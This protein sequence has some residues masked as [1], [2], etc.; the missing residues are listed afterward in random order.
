MAQ[1][2]HS[3]QIPRKTPLQ[4]GSLS[5]S[6]LNVPSTAHN[7]EVAAGFQSKAGVRQKSPGGA[8]IVDELDAGFRRA[9]AHRAVIRVV[10]MSRPDQLSVAQFEQD[11]R[12]YAIGS[13]ATM[14]DKDRDASGKSHFVDW[15]LGLREPDTRSA[16]AFVNETNAGGLSNWVRFAELAPPFN[17]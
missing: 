15:C 16:P 3:A 6:S 8:A 5:F 13:P 12:R 11:S 7:T 2:P 4:L 17:R 10:S 14:D 1:R 9:A